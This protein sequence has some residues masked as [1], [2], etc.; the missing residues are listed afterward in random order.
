MGSRSRAWIRAAFV[1]VAL[2]ALAGVA[3][4]AAA[5]GTGQT[6]APTDGT[7]ADTHIQACAAE[8]PADYADPDSGTD[9]VVGWVDGY[10]YDEPLDI[11]I[12]D[13]LT[14][15]ELDVL[16]ART[17][18]RFE[19]MRCLDADGTPPVEIQTREEFAAELGEAFGNVSEAERLFDNA[20]FEAMLAVSSGADSI[21]VREANRAATTGGFYNFQEDRIVIVSDS[22]DSLLIDEE[23]LAH[24]VGHAI[25]DQRFNLSRFDRDTSDLDIGTQGLIEGDVDRVEYQYLQACEEELWEEPCLQEDFGEGG[26]GGQEEPASWALYFNNFQPYSDGPTFIEHVYEQGGWEAV[27]AVYDNPPRSS[28]EVINPETYGEFER[29]N[30]TVPDRSTGEWE[31]L[32]FDD[33]PNYDVIGQAGITATFMQ[34]PYETREQDD[35]IIQPQSFLNLGPEGEVDEFDPLEYDHPETDG[36]RNDRLY[37]YR[38][39]NETGVVWKLAWANS[40]E[41]AQFATAYRELVAFRGG[42][43]HPDYENVYTFE[44]ATEWDLTV[45]VETR[46]DRVVIVTAPGVDDLTAVHDVALV[47]ADEGAADDGE[48]ADDS[49]DNDDTAG[50]GAGDT[51]ADGPGF[52]VVVAVAGL[53]GALLLARRVT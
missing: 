39:G 38:N 35:I 24:E 47:E 11:D 30:L 10:W 22:P 16:A 23:V 53:V 19:A 13:G 21:E 45:A 29:E 36:W 15:D 31:R 41:A 6:V 8:P 20:M 25:Q 51:D 5:D 33:G 42:E 46:G 49:A 27:N 14:P 52:G 34:V 2:L 43:R 12:S 48:T 44:N 37:V 17:A 4:V 7:L 32:T 3:G 50:D 1:V 9:G 18:A 28:A 40:T 26:G